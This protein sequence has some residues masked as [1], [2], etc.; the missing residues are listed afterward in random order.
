MHP[1]H[2]QVVRG[3]WHF[4]RNDGKLQ[5]YS[6]DVAEELERVFVSQPFEMDADGMLYR[7][8]CLRMYVNMFVGVYVNVCVCMC[9]L[10]WMLMACCIGTDICLCMYVNI[11]LRS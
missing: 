3:T 7:Y 8:V 4:V 1:P 6:E 11:C 2:V 10:R 9:L 5:P